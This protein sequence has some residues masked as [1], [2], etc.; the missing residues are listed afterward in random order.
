MFTGCC[1]SSMASLEH[2][3]SAPPRSPYTGTAAVLIVGGASE[4][5]EIKPNT[6]RIILK[7]R[8]GFVKLALKCG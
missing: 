2:L 4:A 1:S 6:Q 3:L 7:R 8:K 5:M